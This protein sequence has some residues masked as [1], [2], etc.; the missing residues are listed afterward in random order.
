MS[1]QPETAVI[2][3]ETAKD[4]VW[5]K[6]AKYICAGCCFA[7]VTTIIVPVVMF[8]QQGITSWFA[9]AICIIIMANFLACGIAYLMEYKRITKI[10]SVMVVATAGV[11]ILSAIAGFGPGILPAAVLFLLYRNNQKLSPPTADV[12]QS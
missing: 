5:N 9:T 10:A 6:Q 11:L 4:F 8:Y 7:L 1:S 2:T 3:P 12:A